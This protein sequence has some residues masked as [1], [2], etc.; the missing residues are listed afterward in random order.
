MS[1]AAVDPEAFVPFGLGSLGAARTAG[2][3]ANL[4]VVPKDA[5]A[6]EF[7]PL[8]TSP[9]AHGHGAGGSATGQ[10]TLTLQRDGDKIT[11]IRVECSCGQVIDLA[12]SY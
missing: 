8:Q 6:Q 9:A 3:P 10:P 12:C 11:G 4:K 7:S 2:G 1:S 5:G